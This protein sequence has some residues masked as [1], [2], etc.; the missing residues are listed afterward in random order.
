M[1]FVHIADV[2]LGMRPE[3][4]SVIS[5]A[6]ERELFDSFYNI[7]RK[8]GAENTDLLLIAGDLFHRQPKVR[9]LKE[10]DACFAMYPEMRVVLIAGNHDYIGVGS[11]YLSFKWS[12]NVHFIASKELT[13]VY[14]ED[15]NVEVTGFSYF[16]RNIR[17]NVLKNVAAVD[18][19]KINILLAHGGAPDNVPFV[20]K[21]LEASGFDYIA[22][23]HIHKP[24]PVGSLG[25]YPGS[26][27]PLDKNE[28]GKHGYICGE[29]LRAESGRFVVNTQFIE[30]ACREYVKTAIQVDS[31]MTNLEVKSIL[32]NVISS[33]GAQNYYCFELVGRRDPEM[34]FDLGAMLGRRLLTGLPMK[35]SSE[36]ALE[37]TEQGEV[38]EIV[39]NTVPDYDFDKLSSENKDNVIGMFIDAVKAEE[40]EPDLMK[41]ALF[42]GVAALQGID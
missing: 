5:E 18:K 11:P 16:T 13:S 9:E 29:I 41:K 6:R 21:E 39:D 36:L 30:C 24:G 31:A 25:K 33:H 34:N 42:Y 37:V 23:G 26:L 7:V 4:D 27:E 14:F 32:Q 10:L 28:N 3:K 38:L 40:V 19:S 17:E 8:A 35:N 1:K 15:I 20:E 22:L 12:E 2:H